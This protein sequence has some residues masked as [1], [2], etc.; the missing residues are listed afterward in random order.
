MRPILSERNIVVLL[1]VGHTECVDLAHLPLVKELLCEE[2][3]PGFPDRQVCCIM[4][5][6]WP[7]RSLALLARCEKWSSSFCWRE[8]VEGSTGVFPTMGQVVIVLWVVTIFQSGRRAGGRKWIHCARAALSF[9]SGEWETRDSWFGQWEKRNARFDYVGLVP[10]FSCLVELRVH[11][12][13]NRCEQCRG[14][15]FFLPSSRPSLIVSLG[16]WRCPTRMCEGWAIC[17]SRG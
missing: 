6:L 1:F 8:D 12:S 10:N 14:Q 2:D 7:C 3:L 4:F 5:V 9:G 17:A 11:V 15:D 16:A 13:Q